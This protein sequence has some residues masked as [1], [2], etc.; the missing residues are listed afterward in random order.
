MW[1]AAIMQDGGSVDA[2]T[3]D[4]QL[5]MRFDVSWKVLLNLLLKLNF[6]CVTNSNF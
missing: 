3:T 2:S 4:S 1:K 5:Q 6:S